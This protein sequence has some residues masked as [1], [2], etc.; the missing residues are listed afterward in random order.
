M[1]LLAEYF[2][3]KKMMKKWKRKN[4]GTNIHHREAVKNGGTS[5]SGNLVRVNKKAH[6]AYHAFLG[7]KT[8]LQI[9]RYLNQLWLP[10]RV[11]VIALP[12]NRVSEALA[13]LVKEGIID[14]AD[15][16][17][18]GASSE[19]LKY[20]GTLDERLHHTQVRPDE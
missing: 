6:A 18:Y 13:L 11:V 1:S 20:H 10:L 3:L 7:I 15:I 8:P 4:K 19:H 16:H 12:T 14:S 5:L 9:V 2:A 17:L